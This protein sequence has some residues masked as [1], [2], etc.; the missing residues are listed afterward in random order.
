MRSSRQTESVDFKVVITLDDPI[1]GAKPGLSASADIVVA[2]REGVVS[3]PIPALTIRRDPASKGEKEE[4][5]VDDDPTR[6][7][8]RNEREG[9]FVVRDGKAYFVPVVTGIAGDR[10]FEVISGLEAGDE[11]V[12]GDFEAIRTLEDEDPVKIEP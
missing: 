11:V 5:V 12:T 1:P 10:F 3:L 8:N 9:V 6:R 7:R 4:E 2:T